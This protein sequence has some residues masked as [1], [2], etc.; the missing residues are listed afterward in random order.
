[1]PRYLVSRANK[2]AFAV[3]IGLIVLVSGLTAERFDAARRTRLWINHSYQVV[4]AIKD[5]DLAV[6]GAETGQRG[7]LLTGRDDYLAPYETALR[8]VTTLAGTL[9][10]LTAND[11]DQRRRLRALSPVL[12][13]KL[14]ELAQTIALRRDAGTDAALRVVLTNVGRDDMT[15][16]ESVLGAMNEAEQHLLRQQLAT[17]STRASTVR[18]VVFLS[19]ALC[20][21]ALLWAARMM[22]SAWSRSFAAEREQRLVAD[23]LRTSLDSLSQG[24]AVF[25]ASLRLTTWNNC[26]RVLLDLPKPMLRTG[27]GYEAVVEHVAD[28]GFRMEAEHEIALRRR[29]TEVVI[30][31]GERRGGHSLELRRTPTPESGFVLTVSDMT[32]RAQAEG[33]LREAQKMQAIGQ[34]TGGI[35]HDFNNLLTV[36]VGNLEVTRAKL[37]DHPAL[38]AR[39]DRASWAAQR[40]A[41]LTGQ[42]LAFARKQPLAPKAIDLAASMPELVPLLRRTLG[43]HIDVRY[44]ETAGLWAAM[45]DAA[46]LET[47]VLN[48]ALNAR[49]AMPGG[50]RL[51][52]ELANKVLDEDYAR[53]QTD[54]AAGD[55]AMIAVSDSG[56]GMTAEVL[57]RVFEPF[58]TTKPDGRGTGLGLPMVFGFCKQS[59]GHVRIYSEPGEGTTVRLYLPRAHD[60]VE[61]GGARVSHPVAMPRGTA[62]VL[63]VEDE[64]AVREI[65][66]AI[67]SD[68]GYRVVEAADG[69]EALRVFGQHAATI[70]LLL[71]DV[72][73]PGALKGKEV[74]ERIVAVR[75]N[76]RVLFMSGYTENS[77]VHNGRLDEGVDLIAKPFKRER[78]ARK[79]ALALGYDE[80]A[81]GTAL[82]IVDLK[83]RRSD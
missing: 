22:N 30:Y 27:R 82:N 25:D 7:Y 18:W 78:L 48:L 20:L 3:V 2:L 21:A 34:L 24:V 83:A 73:L 58:F 50:G 5:L 54:I 1:M 63:V 43:E 41:T 67:L 62:T 10:E 16:I 35:A 19:F 80:Q 12:Q 74:A 65:A 28:Q 69:E 42:L 45:A 61:A 81:A 71:T 59:G 38:Q 77:I 75:P 79:V 26:F 55:Y 23:R 37:T 47:A 66:V 53:N 51:T 64:A 11:P 49:D 4:D 52:I 17:M 8:D 29:G 40:G 46:Q 57:A 14:E 72:I 15:R 6:R 9:Q 76:I 60:A 44:V 68:L 39:L 32:K 31:D 56:H 33:V 70:D 13:H 36:I